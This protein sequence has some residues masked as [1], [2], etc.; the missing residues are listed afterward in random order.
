MRRSTGLR[1]RGTTRRPRCIPAAQ[2]LSG[3]EKTRR[4]VPAEKS[5]GVSEIVDAG[6]DQPENA[7]DHGVSNGLSAN[8]GAAVRRPA[9][10]ERAEQS[11]DRGR[12]AKCQL[13]S[14]QQGKRGQ[15]HS[16]HR[17][18][19]EAASARH[20]VDNDHSCRRRRRLPPPGRGRDLY[21]ASNTMWSRL[22]CSH[23]ALRLCPP[24]SITEDRQRAACAKNEDARAARRRDVQQ[25]L[26]PIP[27][28]CPDSSRE[29]TYSAAASHMQRDEAEIVTEIS[30]RMLTPQHLGLRRPQF[31]QRLSRTPT[32]EPHEVQTTEPVV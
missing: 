26:P 30:Q 6:H 14:T 2:A 19:Q 18:E 21:H 9:I 1:R 20:R 5:A 22:P 31:K 10:D 13:R 24:A 12:C 8:Q 16:R 15:I 27:M 32:S 11:K 23:P 28:P 4:Q 7:Q 3:I 25:S 29:I 17:A